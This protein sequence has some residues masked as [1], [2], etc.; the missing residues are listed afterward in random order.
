LPQADIRRP[1][2]SADWGDYISFASHLRAKADAEGSDILLIDTG[3]RIEG[4]GLFDASDPKGKYYYDI[5]K[6]QN[7]DVICSGNHELYKANSS[8][9]ELYQTVPNFKN[10][11]IASNLDIIDPDRGTREPLAPRFRKF[12]TKNQKLRILAFGFL[13]DFTGNADN[14]IVQPVEET[15]KEDWF[16]KALEDREVDVIV[17][18]GHV[19]V[20]MNEFKVIHKA[21]RSAQWDTPVLFFGGHVHVRDYTSYDRKSAAIASGRYMET[22]GFMS[23]DGIPKG[24]KPDDGSKETSASLKFAR[25]YIDNNLFSFYHHSSKNTSTFPTDRGEKVSKQIAKARNTLNLSKKYG[26][27]PTTLYVNRVPY[28]SN[29][30]IFSWLADSVFPQQ[31]ARSPRATR[32][33]KKALAITNTG[34]IRFD[35]FKGP[36]TLDTEFLVS[37]F[38]SGFRFV[39]DVPLREAGRVLELLNGKGPIVQ[40]V[41]MD[42]GLPAWILAPP[43]QMDGRA[44]RLD[45]NHRNRWQELREAGESMSLRDMGQKVMQLVKGDSDENLRPGYTTV[46]DM[47]SDGDDTEHSHVDFFNVPNVVQ[48]SIGFELPP[49]IA[50]VPD[51]ETVDM[52]YSDFV[53]P[54]IIMALQ[55]LGLKIEEKDTA[56]YYDGKSMTNVIT[57]WIHDNWKC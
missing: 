28:P 19:G 27:A 9:A 35:I 17:V 24:K 36:F 40:A 45:S 51:D 23:V 5:Y 26:C 46:D 39:P 3:D 18:I 34:A 53:Q 49:S 30:S 38:T 1:S 29:S 11:Y 20:R 13:F 44:G 21:I 32:A 8:N 12:E 7:V 2:F 33:N 41:A 31:L 4:N 16:K 54:W 15:V 55:Y 50:D 22:V 52:V 42:Q 6:E 57:D 48:A 56:V 37:P 14:T 43:E 10:S 25:R 47:G